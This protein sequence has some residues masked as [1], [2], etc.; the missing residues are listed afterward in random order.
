MIAR[1]L[2]ATPS[3]LLQ[4]STALLIAVLAG[5][6]S[7]SAALA[8]APAAT[9]TTTAETRVAAPDRKRVEIVRTDLVPVVDGV[10]DDEIWRSATV[11]RDVEQYQPGD[12]V[13]PSERS[14]FYLAYSERFFYVAARLFDSDPSGISARQLIQNGT[15][16]FDDAIEFIIDTFNNG[17]T[18]YHFQVNPRGIRQ[19]GM[20]ENPNTLNR[21]WSGI[22]ASESRIDEQ[23]WTAEV[24]IP[25]NTVNF[26][27]ATEEWG[28]TIARTIARRQEEIAWSSFNRNLNPTTTGLITGIRDIRQGVGLD[29]VPSLA[30]ART[31]DYVG[32]ADG[33]RIDP[34]LNVF[35]KITPN[36]TSV[37][38]VNTDFSATE[39]DNRQVNLTRFSLFFPEKRDFFLQDVDIF[40][41]GGRGGGGFSGGG[42]QNGIPFYSRRIG[43]SRS[44]QPVD[45]DAGIKL[46]G[47]VGEWN[48]GA[49]AVQQ[50]ENGSLDAQ[51]LFVGRAALN[52]LSESSLGMIFTSGDPLSE[53]GNALGGLDFRYQNTRFSERYTL[54]GNAFYQQ[55]DTE[56]LDGDDKAYGVR[57]EL[58]TQGTGFGGAVGYEYFG[59]DYRPALGFAN[60]VGV[61]SVTLDGS[62]RYFLRG[63]PFV[64][65]LNSFA[66]Y[67]YTRRLDTQELQSEGLF[68]NVINVNSHRGDQFG[69]NVS[70]DREGLD[71]PF[72]IS[73]GVV[74]PSGKYSFAGAGVQLR[75]SN[76]RL[77]APS[78]RLNRGQ[79]YNGHRSRAQ[80]GAEWRPDEH[81]FMNFSYDY[82]DIQLPAGDFKVRLVSANVVYAFNSRW[83]WINLIQYDNASSSVG[84]NSR[85]R[86]NPVAGEDFYLVLNGGFDSAGVFSQISREKAEIA[87]KY[88]KTFRY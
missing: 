38:T 20:F 70:R 26:D 86:W 34:S 74:L 78:L 46:S 24:A 65:A 51:S 7:V 2:Q 12:H 3:R 84:I 64:R 56:G 36:L 23:G 40:T 73:P 83:S 67:E 60:R 62:A 31:A 57:A 18:G 80:V 85:L 4:G 39:V 33:D 79:F 75:V 8:Q 11:I 87:I 76:Q 16:Q 29:I 9:A 58:D 17:R 30:L 10:L 6:T 35:Y 82:Q 15:M 44:G 43:L 72:Q 19:D 28:F 71:R 88:T 61:E 50:G 55:T 68:W 47:R 81:L 37:L 69:F 25:F 1:N 63:S 59:D 52:V 27:P 48:V 77:F 14:E 5:T 42:R 49:L 66:G 21:D 41:F 53:T 45:I 32:N 13:A 22:W 54:S